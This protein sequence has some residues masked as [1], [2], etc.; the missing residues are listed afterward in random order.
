MNGVRV[1]AL[2]QRSPWDWTDVLLALPLTLVIGAALGF[3]LE[4]VVLPFLPLH[5]SQLRTAV[6]KFVAQLALY[7]ALV[8]SV[9]GLVTVRRRATLQALG[10]RPVA[11]RWLVWTIPLAIAAYVLVVIAGVIVDQLIPQAHN[12]QP[13]AVRDAFGQY[14]LLAVVAVSV[15]APFAE[16]TLFRGFIYGWLRGRVAPWMA[17]SVS[18]LV[19]ALAHGELALLAPIF[20]LGCL[21]AVVYERSGSLYPGMVIHAL[22]NLIGVTLIFSAH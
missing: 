9:V 20:V 4:A 16:E 14:H 19:F 15:I 3:G 18:A 21:L 8:A 22:F 5:D 13:Q 6:A 12:G 1:A 2:R 11:H 7:A 10:W 17:I